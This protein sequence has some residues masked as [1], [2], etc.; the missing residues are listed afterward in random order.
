MSW[1]SSRPVVGVADWIRTSMFSFCRRDPI[2]SRH[3]DSVWGVVPDSNRCFPASQAGALAA[4]LTTPSYTNIRD[5]SVHVWHAIKESNPVGKVLEAH[6][7]PYLHGI[8]FGGRHSIRK[9]CGYPHDLLSRQSQNPVWFIFHCLDARSG[10][11]PE[12]ATSEDAVLPLHHQAVVW[13]P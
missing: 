7:I 10:F 12:V 4:M 3:C 11:E 9:R 13:C 2:H 6:P 1:Q 5:V 8:L